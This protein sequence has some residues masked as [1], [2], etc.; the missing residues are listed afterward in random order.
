MYCE[1][2]HSYKYSMCVLQKPARYQSRQNPR[3]KV[4][5]LIIVITMYGCGIKPSVS[6]NVNDINTVIEDCK[7]QPQFGI[8][9][10]F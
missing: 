9:K 5:V 4:I 1:D 2:P 6:C 7:K 3:M 10:E 8:S